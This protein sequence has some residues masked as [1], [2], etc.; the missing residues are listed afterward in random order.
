MNSVEQFESITQMLPTSAL[1]IL[2]WLL[3][4]I[5][6]GMTVTAAMIFW[7]HWSNYALR[8]ATIARYEVAFLAVAGVIIG[9]MIS[10]SFYLIF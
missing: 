5:A 2:A 8:T 6:I 4:V 7:Y 9:I 3:T 1:V 10:L